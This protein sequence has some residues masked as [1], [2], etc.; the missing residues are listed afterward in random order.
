MIWSIVSPQDDTWNYQNG[1]VRIDYVVN[2]YVIGDEP[3]GGPWTQVSAA[4]DTWV[5]Q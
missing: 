3:S 5:V 2:D 4:S 1:Y